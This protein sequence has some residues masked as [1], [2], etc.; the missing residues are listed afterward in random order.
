[1][2]DNGILKT[3]RDEENWNVKEKVDWLMKLEEAVLPIPQ[4]A[5]VSDVKM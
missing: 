4:G 3:A 1:M 2:G 5:D